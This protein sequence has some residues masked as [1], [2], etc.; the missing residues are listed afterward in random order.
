MKEGGGRARAFIDSLLFW[1]AYIWPNFLCGANHVT[2]RKYTGLLPSIINYAKI[3][4]YFGYS[5]IAN[6]YVFEPK[7]RLAQQ[8]QLGA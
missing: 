1:G 8:L 6:F 7:F 3:C 5:Q 4:F 2:H